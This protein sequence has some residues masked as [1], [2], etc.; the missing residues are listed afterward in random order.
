MKISFCN[1]EH[2]VKIGKLVF[3]FVFDDMGNAWDD[4]DF[5]FDQK[6]KEFECTKLFWKLYWITN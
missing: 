5:F 2:I 3:V 4:E 1:T 6:G